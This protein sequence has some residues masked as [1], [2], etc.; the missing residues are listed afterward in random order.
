[1]KLSYKYLILSV[2]S[3]LIASAS[4]NFLNFELSV[5][6]E[7][8]G[9]TLSFLGY[10]AFTNGVNLTNVTEPQ[11]F[12]QTG[13]WDYI[14]SRDYISFRDSTTEP[15]FRIQILMSSS[16]SGD[17]VYTG[18]SMSQTAID[19]SNFKIWGNYFS[20]T[21]LEPTMAVDDDTET[22]SIHSDGSCI[23]AEE[24]T[25]YRFHDDLA[26]PLKDYSLTMSSIE[27]EYFSSGMYC[28]V[29]GQIDI[30]RM[31]LLYPPSSANGI[32]Q[33][34]MIIL[35]VDGGTGPEN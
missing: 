21:P 34:Q 3:F 26:D 23:Y 15:G 8:G 11:N 6:A 1:M 16:Q 29:E 4:F 19:V 14:E 22:L 13:S 32:Y 17:F 2:F 35:L 25:Y 30:R 24:L 12:S 7:G 5:M 27:Q 28:E 10:G 18:S 31:E 20:G 33:S 9:D